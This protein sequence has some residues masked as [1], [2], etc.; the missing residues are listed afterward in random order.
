MIIPC[1]G[2]RG[3]GTRGIG[4]LYACVSRSPAGLPIEAFILDPARFWK[5]G[6]FR[7]PIIYE[8]PDG[9]FDILIWVGA[10]FYP[11]IPDF[12]EEAR[13]MGISRRIPRGFPIEKLTPGESRMIL[14]HSR[15]VPQF[16]YQALPSGKCQ[17]KEVDHLCTFDTWSLSSL[18]SVQN[19]VTYS[20]VW[21][22]AVE[23]KTPSVVYK[24]N[25][26][27]EIPE[28]RPYVAGAF[29]AFFLTH[30]EFISSEGKAPRELYEKA[31]GSG[32]DLL[33]LSD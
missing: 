22:S 11:F 15:A 24:V 9:I 10:E 21:D 29:A 17:K 28:E 26:C 2:A 31:S 1:S 20:E 25:K 30:L 19:H 14:I 7:A 32:I 6:P 12:I 16:D 23:I 33:I 5:G 4:G 18:N 13:A 8:R 27:L 3:C